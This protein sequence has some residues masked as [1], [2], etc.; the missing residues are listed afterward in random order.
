MIAMSASS[1]AQ[2]SE[3]PWSRAARSAGRPT[4]S[5]CG[6]PASASPRAPAAPKRRRARSPW[7]SRS[8]TGA[9]RSGQL[10]QQRRRGRHRGGAPLRRAAHR[11]PLRGGG[12]QE[13]ERPD[14]AAVRVA[15][16]GRLQHRPLHVAAEASQLLA[17]PQRQR[18]AG[19]R[20]RDGA[21]P[22]AQRLRRATQAGQIEVAMGAAAAPVDERRLGRQ[23]RLVDERR[24]REVRQLQLR[25]GRE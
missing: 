11:R 14:G 5:A 8:R 3:P 9:K 10:R 20:P 16:A 7:L 2:L 13:A 23:L 4:T 21:E 6:K 12:D 22:R 19:G 1:R 24:D 25:H 17:Q 18:L 15:A